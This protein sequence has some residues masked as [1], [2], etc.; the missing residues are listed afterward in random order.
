MLPGYIS[1]IGVF[2]IGVIL[3]RSLKEQMF[4]R[5]PVF[6]SYLA[7]VLAQSVIRFSAYAVRPSLYADIYWYTEFLGILVGCGVIWEIYSQALATYAGVVR[8][9]RA[10]II[11]AILMALVW[12]WIARSAQA[13]P[14]LALDAAADLDRTLRGVQTIFLILLV[15]LLLYY[16]IPLGRNLKGMVVGYG[17]YVG[18]TMVALGVRHLV[19]VELQV[20]PFAYTLALI[21]WCATLWSYVPNPKTKGTPKIEAD[22][23]AV[24][25]MALEAITQA[26]RYLSRMARS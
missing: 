5:Y 14:P 25:G 8:V 24:S 13:S 1:L 10:S 19:G 18:I 12:V 16:A 11:L 6:Y 20:Q 22:Y 21:I 23:E 9:A 4:G 26:R 3:A 7:Y 17:A 2:L 15:T